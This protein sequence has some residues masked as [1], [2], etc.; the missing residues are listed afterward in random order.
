MMLPKTSSVNMTAARRVE[1]AR[2]VMKAKPQMAASWT[3]PFST[4]CHLSRPKGKKSSPA[5]H[6]TS[7]TCKPETQSR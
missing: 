2:P 7:P 3:E 5:I 4:R 6:A 1:G